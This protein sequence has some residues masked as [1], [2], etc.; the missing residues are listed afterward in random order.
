VV[1]LSVDESGH[2]QLWLAPLDASSP[3]R[4]LASPEYADRALFDPHGGVLFVGGE[5]GVYYLYHVN[6]DGTGLR[7]LFPGPVSFL[8]AISPDGM[9]MA[10]WVGFDIYVVAYDG[11]SRTLICKGC[12]T[13]GEENRGVTPAILSWS[14]D[15]KF[16]YVHY[17]GHRETYAVPLRPGRLLPSL[18]DKGLAHLAEAKSLPGAKTFPELRAFAGPDPSVY[19]YPRVTTH[20]NIYRIPV[21]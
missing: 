8:Y 16:L 11:S 17:T 21:P 6:D 14:S 4:R 12:G 1:F 20:R 10:V 9:A 5:G 15:Q 7:K 2:S 18:D 3:P 19:A 13:A